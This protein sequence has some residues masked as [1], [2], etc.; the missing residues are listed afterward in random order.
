MYPNPTPTQSRLLSRVDRHAAERAFAKQ[1][2]RAI[3]RLERLGVSGESARAWIAAW[4]RS[5]IDLVDFRAAG[6]FWD[7]GFQYA[8]EEIR[9]GFDPPTWDGAEAREAS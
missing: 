3:E 6:D 1:R 9:A 7:L 5:T 2:N 4:D 8:R